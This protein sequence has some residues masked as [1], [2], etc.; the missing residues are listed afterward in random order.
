MKLVILSMLISLFMISPAMA[1]DLADYPAEFIKNGRFN[2]QSVV[3][4]D[5]PAGKT[6]AATEMTNTLTRA[7]GARTPAP[8]PVCKTASPERT[9]DTMV[10]AARRSTSTATARSISRTSPPSS[11]S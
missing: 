9:P 3:G 2:A 11:G 6:L 5:A 10:R 8:S 1:Y 7:T 4:D